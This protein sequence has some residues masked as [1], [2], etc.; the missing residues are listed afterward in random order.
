MQPLFFVLVALLLF[1]ISVKAAEYSDGDSCTNAGAYHQNN[2]TDG[3]Y[4]LTCDGTYW[5]LIMMYD[6]HHNRVGIKT[7]NPAASLDVNGNIRHKGLILSISDARKKDNINQLTHTLSKLEQL[8]GVSYVMKDDPERDV[9]L[10]LIA[11]D[12]EK[13]YPELVKTDAYDSKTL[14]YSGLIAP[15]VE[16]IKELNKENEN[17]KKTILKIEAKINM[18]E[19]SLTP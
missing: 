14:N 3:I 7:D 2:D 4:F 17:L 15:M 5:Q 10:G 8:R 11:Q 13:V 18:I 16:A 6:V 19:N 9:I 1:S 12:V